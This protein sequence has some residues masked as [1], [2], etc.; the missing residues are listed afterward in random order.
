METPVINNVFKLTDC[1]RDYETN[2]VRYVMHFVFTPC[3]KGKYEYI[4][5]IPKKGSK[6]IEENALKN[7]KNLKMVITDKSATS[8]GEC[9]FYECHELTSKTI[10]DSSHFD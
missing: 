3:S 5:A 10:P 9:A 7:I 8:I 2:L 1:I 4:R 6:K